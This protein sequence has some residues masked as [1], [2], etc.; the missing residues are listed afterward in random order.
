MSFIIIINY[1]CLFANLV[2]CR[3]ITCPKGTEVCKFESTYAADGK[4][5]EVKYKCFGANS[6]YPTRFYLSIAKT[7][8]ID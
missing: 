1:Y 6:N 4:T 3:N 8:I 7:L 5:A 2:E